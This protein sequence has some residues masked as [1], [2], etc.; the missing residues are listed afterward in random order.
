MKILDQSESGYQWKLTSANEVTYTDASTSTVTF[1]VS[2][3]G[4]ITYSKT[5]GSS[6]PY[7]SSYDTYATI[8]FICNVL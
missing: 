6:S 7:G 8:E 4:Y 1:T 2:I 3:D 5:Q